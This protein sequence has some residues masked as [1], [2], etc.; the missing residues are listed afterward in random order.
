MASGFIQK[1]PDHRRPSSPLAHN[2]AAPREFPATDDDAS[3]SD[4]PIGFEITRSI[5]MVLSDGLMLVKNHLLGIL[6]GYSR[7]HD[8]NI[9]MFTVWD[10]ILQV[11]YRLRDIPC[12]IASKSSYI[13]NIPIIA[14][15]L[16]KQCHKPTPKKYDKMGMVG[17]FLNINVTLQFMLVYRL[18]AQIC[19]NKN[20]QT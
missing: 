2:D 11:S 14:L 16:V 13:W 17:F 7:E 6:Y 20:V 9:T 12:S 10:I 8:G 3:R 5:E 18:Y 4:G 15:M 1:N 19:S